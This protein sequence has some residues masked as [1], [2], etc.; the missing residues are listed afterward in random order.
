MA[1]AALIVALLLGVASEQ[2]T[3]AKQALPMDSNAYLQYDG[4][5]AM[6]MVLPASCSPGVCEMISHFWDR[7]STVFPHGCI[8]LLAWLTTTLM[9]ASKPPRRPRQCLWNMN[10]HTGR[11]MPA[12]GAARACKWRWPLE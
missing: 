7:L 1:A 4:P 10:S 3:K 11:C 12:I 5:P 9:R 6:V 8:V 2:E